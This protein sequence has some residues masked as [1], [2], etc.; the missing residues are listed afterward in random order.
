MPRT[1]TYPISVVVK[2]TGLSRRQ[3]A[4]LDPKIKPCSKS[5]APQKRQQG[6]YRHRRY[7]RQQIIRIAAI[8]GVKPKIKGL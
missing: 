3:I 7:T 8:K 2:A 4:Y 1:K 5:A 6:L